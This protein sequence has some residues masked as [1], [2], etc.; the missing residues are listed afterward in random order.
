M[1]T[2]DNTR[3]ALK[4]YDEGKAARDAAW[5]AIETDEDVAAREAADSADLRK[6][7]DAFHRD[8]AAYN[9]LENC[10]LLHIND[11]RRYEKC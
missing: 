3:A 1:T 5:D 2:F 7:Q 6:V 8:T 10:R 4:V 11:L 9:S